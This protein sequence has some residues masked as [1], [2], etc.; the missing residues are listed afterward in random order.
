MF[1]WV[2]DL[3]RCRYQYTEYAIYV[4]KDDGPPLLNDN[5]ANGR[6]RGT[7]AV[8]QVTRDEVGLVALDHVAEGGALDDDAAGLKQVLD[9]D[10]GDGEG[11]G[12]F[13]GSLEAGEEVGTAVGG[14]KGGAAAGVAPSLADGADG[15]DALVVVP[16]EEGAHVAADEAV[17]EGAVEGA[18]LGG[19][20]KGVGQGQLEAVLADDELAA[21][22][23]VGQGGAP[24]A[25]VDLAVEVGAEV[26]RLRPKRLAAAAD[27]RR[28]APAQTRAAGALLRPHL[29]VRAVHVVA[30]LG[31]RRALARVVALVHDGQVQ[32]VAAQRQVQVLGRPHLEGPGLEAGKGKDGDGDEAGGGR[33]EGMGGEGGR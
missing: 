3:F 28:L 25:V 1:G 7:H 27:Q 5:L 23:A 32:Q 18:G 12:V 6:A 30:R 29:A 19:L 17:F 33:G 15:A 31:R 2:F 4:Y 24:G 11:A 21:A 20:Q 14:D 10:V 22:V 26:A 9:V 13:A 8:D 16:V